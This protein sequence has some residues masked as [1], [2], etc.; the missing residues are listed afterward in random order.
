MHVNHPLGFFE[1]I[2][3]RQIVGV[4][5]ICL[6]S[7]SVILAGVC[8][9]DVKELFKRGHLHSSLRSFS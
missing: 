1:M 8:A 6:C 2:E 5:G 9:D 4:F 3:P 7:D